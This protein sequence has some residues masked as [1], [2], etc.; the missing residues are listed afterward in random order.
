MEAA[1]GRSIDAAK[2]LGMEEQKLW[3]CI[4]KNPELQARWSKTYGGVTPPG[5]EV[6]LS[7]PM[8]PE[9]VE[10]QDMI[11]ANEIDLA[12]AMER[13][14]KLV[15]KGLD[16]MGI[17][18]AAL[19]L[20]TALQKFQRRHFT[21]AMEI[22]GGGVVKQYLDLMVEI[23]KINASLDDPEAELEPQEELMLREDRSRLLAMQIK[24][25]EQVQQAV[26]IQAKV[27][28]IKGE[29]K[30]SGKPKGFLAIQAQTGSN[31][32]VRLEGDNTEIQSG[33]GQA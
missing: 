8:M 18:G 3:N 14:D 5:D 27:K 7:R 30:K 1:E 26:V 13:E 6:A 31:V 33:P 16:A 12:A 25:Y 22:V 4:N 17:K 10:P 29:N 2:A 24:I 20:A 21:Q 19:D 28:A 32:S 9:L 11:L 15:R 23:Q